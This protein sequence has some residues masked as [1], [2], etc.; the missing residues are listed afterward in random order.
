MV[1]LNVFPCRKMEMCVDI[2][3]IKVTLLLTLLCICV[4]VILFA[5]EFM[6]NLLR[7]GQRAKGS[8]QRKGQTREETVLPYGENC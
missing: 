8:S 7:A 5:E 3:I 2:Y 4:F 1:T 6:N